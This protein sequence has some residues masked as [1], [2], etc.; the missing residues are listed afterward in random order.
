MA[1]IYASDALRALVEAAQ[2]AT[3]FR[4]GCRLCRF[5]R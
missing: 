1:P 5:P 2:Q 4:S 3:D